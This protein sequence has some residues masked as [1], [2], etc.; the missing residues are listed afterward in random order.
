MDHRQLRV[1]E[2]KM[3]FLDKDFL[4]IYLQVE[5][6]LNSFLKL[7][8]WNEARVFVGP[9]CLKKGLKAP[10]LKSFGRPFSE[11]FVGS[12]KLMCFRH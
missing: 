4:N 10:S 8:I 2:L 12:D 11:R 7:G 5:I 3:P 9:E 1:G 6:Q